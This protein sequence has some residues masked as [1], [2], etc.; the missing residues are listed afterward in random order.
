MAKASGHRPGGGIASR[1][2]VEKPMRQGSPR[3]RIRHAGVAQIGIRV[4]N[5]PTN[6]DATSYGGINPFTGKEGMPSQLGNANAAELAG[7]KNGSGA[8]RNIYKS[9][10]QG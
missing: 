1:Q 7:V 2:R 10:S 4:G 6:R 8:K 3:E 9:G 5:H